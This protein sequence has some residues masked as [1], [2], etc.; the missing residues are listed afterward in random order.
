M[1]GDPIWMTAKFNSICP[2]TNQP[3]RK[4]DE[5]LYYPKSKKAYHID[6]PTA[7]NW[8]QQQQADSYGLLDANW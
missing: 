3:I 8:Q 5:M 7:A 4:G 1:K 6:S 2:E